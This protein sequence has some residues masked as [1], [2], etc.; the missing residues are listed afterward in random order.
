M[1]TLP[2]NPAPTPV[3]ATTTNS[4]RD[5]DRGGFP[6]ALAKAADDQRGTRDHRSDPERENHRA[7]NG[8]AHDDL[9]ADRA[10]KIRS[11]AQRAMNRAV[12]PR[13]PA[14][15][16]AVQRRSSDGADLERADDAR[17]DA[18]A[19]AVTNGL[20][21]VL[22]SLLGAT[23]ADDGRVHAGQLPPSIPAGASGVLPGMAGATVTGGVRFG[24]PT[25]DAGRSPTMSGAVP[26]A[27][28]AVPLVPAGGAVPVTTFA[29]PAGA[30]GTAGT[31]GVAP[32]G[33]G[34]LDQTSTLGADGDE[35]AGSGRRPGPGTAPSGPIVAGRPG[36]P[37]QPAVSAAATG[38]AAAGP[39]GTPDTSPHALPNATP[40]G[41]TTSPATAA[42]ST[43]APGAGKPP[44]GASTTDAS[45]APTPAS[46][47]ATGGIATGTIATGLTAT[48]A[49]SAATPV[50]GG[51][52]TAPTDATAGR[53]AAGSA[54]PIGT[55]PGD[56]TTRTGTARTGSAQDGTAQDGTARTGTAANNAPGMNTPGTGTPD[57]IART[58][59]AATLGGTT[60]PA[61]N[62]SGADSGG[63]PDGLPGGRVQWRPGPQADQSTGSFTGIGLAAARVLADADPASR[64]PEMSG[65]GADRDPGTAAAIGVGLPG[66]P[67]QQPSEVRPTGAPTAGQSNAPATPAAQVATH[68]I[69]LRQQPDGVHRMTIQLNPGDLGPI[70]VMAEIRNGAISVHLAGATDA[71]REAL[72]AA[73]PDLRR[74]LEAGGFGSTAVEL[75][76]TPSDS[77]R[78]R[79]QQLG[80]Q[81]GGQ[82]A[83]QTGG[84]RPDR[85]TGS[86]DRHGNPTTDRPGSGG[87]SRRNGTD[88][89]TPGTGATGH[90]ALDLRV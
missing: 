2:L 77:G 27:D 39:L 41:P 29:A 54:T 30:S 79:D 71:G 70:S 57:A 86:E 37:V 80:G 16:A 12:G 68:L 65:T 43:S 6:A 18:L 13:E 67:A 28:A 14:G 74:E 7:D 78:H 17:D 8:P 60:G 61:G 40:I 42:L 69:P 55:T 3:A 89:A 84:D 24:A 35:R 52:A 64:V 51:T 25:A 87:K 19:E 20:P 83:G 90:R 82:L 58:G 34:A 5:R 22:N 38:V 81:P 49:A 66:T 62:R 11:A 48:G 26:G 46:A 4:G 33:A 63:H 32:T 36:G 45:P 75:R 76:Q 31:P 9:A 59:T 73:L 53:A 56:G 1:I 10:A 23:P 47:L 72:L 21:L 15:W 85:Q 50:V 88:A 44:T